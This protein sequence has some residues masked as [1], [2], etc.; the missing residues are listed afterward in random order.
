MADTLVTMRVLLVL[1]L[2]PG[3]VFLLNHTLHSGV[4]SCR[5]RCGQSRTLPCSCDARCVVYNNCCLDVLQFCPETV[6]YGRR[7]FAGQIEAGVVCK[8]DF[9]FVANCPNMNETS[10]RNDNE[11]IMSYRSDDPAIFETMLEANVSTTHNGFWRALRQAPVLELS[12]GISYLNLSVFA[13]F[14]RNLSDFVFWDVK[15]PAKE[16]ISI[17]TLSSMIGS[18]STYQVIYDKNPYIPRRGENQYTNGACFRYL[19]DECEAS[20]CE[21]PLTNDTSDLVDKCPCDSY[22]SFVTVG[23]A[24]YKNEI[25][26]RCNNVTA[27]SDYKK[28]NELESHLSSLSVARYIFTVTV[29]KNDLFFNYDFGKTVDYRGVGEEYSSW[30]H[31][32]CKLPTIQNESGECQVLECSRNYTMRPNG[33]CGTLNWIGIG[34]SQDEFPITTQQLDQMNEFLHC[35]LEYLDLFKNY[36]MQPTIYQHSAEGRPVYIF[37]IGYYSDRKYDLSRADSKT[38]DLISKILDLAKSFKFYRVQAAGSTSDHHNA[39]MK[40][41]NT[42]IHVRQPPNFARQRVEDIVARLEIHKG[43]VMKGWWS[44]SACACD[45][46]LLEGITF[47]CTLFCVHDRVFEKDMEIFKS[48]ACRDKLSGKN[49]GDLNR[50]SYLHVMTSVIVVTIFTSLFRN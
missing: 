43:K 44:V 19:I 15:F 29:G 46:L 35:E 14:N 47:D 4:Y 8:S 3:Y 23:Y 36:V 10:D 18:L 21:Q 17:T 26:A 33:G 34:V 28:L 5:D 2:Q 7:R 12:T 42:Q 24:I 37:P 48:S 11:S 31:A 45:L 39:E 1:L 20:F 22:F 40:E 41:I 13:C 38:V 32:S 25:C 49:A 9:L 16:F 27:P 50:G 6:S 30:T